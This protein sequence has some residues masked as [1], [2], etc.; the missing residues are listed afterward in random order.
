MGRN[1]SGA[2]GCMRLLTGIIMAAIA[3]AAVIFFFFP[4]LSMRYFTVSW[5]SVR[6]GK[7][8]YEADFTQAFD[9]I[10]SSV[11]QALKEAGVTGADAGRLAASIDTDRV[12]ASLKE[13]GGSIRDHADDL[14]ASIVD[15]IDPAEAG[16]PEGVDLEEVQDALERELSELDFAGVLRDLGSDAEGFLRQL[17]EKLRGTEF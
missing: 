11:E 9:T 2:G 3:A 6:G 16:I 12:L 7:S 4:E 10:S 5:E 8:D 13:S 15:S 14:A 1:R 17:L